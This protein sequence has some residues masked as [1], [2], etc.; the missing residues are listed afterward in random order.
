MRLQSGPGTPP[1]MTLSSSRVTGEISR[2]ELVSQISSALNS[3]LLG[4]VGFTKRDG[5]IGGQ[6]DEEVTG[7]AG[8][9]GRAVGWR[10]QQTVA[11]DEKIAG[12]AF[13]GK[14]VFI[15]IASRAVAVQ[16]PVVAT[17]RWAA[18]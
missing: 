14:S 3:C 5:V 13:D 2:V 4:N 1:L 12:G 17:I 10:N 15:R 6:F 9:Q 8:Q 16:W 11:D 18:G 7:N